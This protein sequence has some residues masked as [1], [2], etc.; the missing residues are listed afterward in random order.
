MHKKIELELPK[1]S[2]FQENKV[3]RELQ[4]NIDMQLE[5]IQDRL[6]QKLLS[7]LDDVKGILEDAESIIYE[8]YSTMGFFTNRYKNFSVLMFEY[9]RLSLRLESANLEEKTSSLAKQVE[10]ST[11]TVNALEKDMKNHLG[12]LVGLFLTF[13]L[14]PTAITGFE[15][16]SGRYL[17]PFMMSIA[18]FGIIMISYIY[19][20]NHCK[21]TK[22]ALIFLIAAI[23]VTV[24]L[25]IVSFNIDIGI[26]ESVQS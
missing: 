26:I 16:I 24:A 20:L 22:G 23:T 18:T 3:I 9:Q 4:D 13:T 7:D 19:T 15:K 6:Q 10:Q 11:E 25:W 21:M 2:D 12:T 8:C 17:A 14:I 5:V 1:L